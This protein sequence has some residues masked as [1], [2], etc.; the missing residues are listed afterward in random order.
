VAV[1]AEKSR[2]ERLRCAAF[3]GLA[4]I[5]EKGPEV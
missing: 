5:M 3:I 2:A 4:G 1:K